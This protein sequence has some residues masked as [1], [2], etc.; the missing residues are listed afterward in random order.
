LVEDVVLLVNQKG[1]QISTD[2]DQLLDPGLIRYP[3]TVE[4]PQFAAQVIEELASTGDTS[5]RSWLYYVWDDTDTSDGLPRFVFAPRDL[6]DWEYEIELNDR[7]LAAFTH[8]RISTKLQN[9]VTVKY[10]DKKNLAKYLTL[11]D[12][13]SIDDEY[14]RDWFINIGQSDATGAFYVAQRFIEYHKNRQVRGS[15]SQKGFIRTKGNGIKPV[16]RVHAGERFKLINT[17]EIFFIRYTSYTAETRTIQI[18]PDEPEDNLAMLEAQRQR[19]LGAL[20]R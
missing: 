16:N 11:T 10:T 6:T 18:S 14:R 1:A 13:A 19:G 15:L 4:D 9:A 3:F 7:E 5:L 8:E 2:F 12:T 20:A 17:G